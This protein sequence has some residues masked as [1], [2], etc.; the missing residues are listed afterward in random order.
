[1]IIFSA[2]STLS[3]SVSSAMT[4]SRW[5]LAVMQSRG[6]PNKKS[7]Y[8][9]HGRE[10]QVK[11][12]AGTPPATK[13]HDIN[14]RGA[15]EDAL[16]SRRDRIFSRVDE[17]YGEIRSQKRYSHAPDREQMPRFGRIFL[18]DVAP[19]PHDKIVADGPRIG[20]FA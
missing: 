14:V 9:Y 10:I 1:M 13:A 12:P 4:S 17:G 18:S 6:K 20:V 16:L 8:A 15:E 7:Q 19:E 11:G 5:V 2:R 3:N